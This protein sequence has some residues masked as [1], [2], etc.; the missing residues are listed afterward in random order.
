MFKRKPVPTGIAPTPGLK[1]LMPGSFLSHHEIVDEMDDEVL[2]NPWNSSD[3]VDP[4]GTLERIQDLVATAASNEQPELRW[5]TVDWR[6]FDPPKA[7]RKA[8]NVTSQIIL[9]I[10]QSS[11]EN[12]RRRA[13]DERR[14]ELLAEEQSLLVQLEARR[15]K[16]KGKEPYLP[17]IMVEDEPLPGSS[18]AGGCHL[19]TG[20]TTT[21]NLVTTTDPRPSDESSLRSYSASDLA[22]APFSQK[23]H[24]SRESAIRRLFKRNTEK[25]ESSAEGSARESLL[26]RLMDSR[27]SN[28]SKTPEQTTEDAVAKLKK[29]LKAA[30]QPEITV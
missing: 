9:D 3:G 26:Q 15:A 13:A 8:P 25:G 19:P 14:Q 7:L 20:Q 16:Q 28:S 10:V 21:K 4:L 2:H 27:G 1:V 17:I 18:S 12:V 23:L 29:R 11:I 5:T 6:K 24:K 30:Q 22:A